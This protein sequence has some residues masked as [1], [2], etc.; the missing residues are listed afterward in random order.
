M[1][2][3]EGRQ[4]TILTERKQKLLEGKQMRKQYSNSGRANCK[5]AFT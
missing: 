2:V 5:E 4:N 1:D 3:L